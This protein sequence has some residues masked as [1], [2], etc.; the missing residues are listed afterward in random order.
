MND[1]YDCLKGPS[2]DCAV[3]KPFSYFINCD[4]NIQK[5]QGISHPTQRRG[6]RDNAATPLRYAAPLR[7]EAFP[8]GAV[9]SRDRWLAYFFPMDKLYCRLETCL[10]DIPA[11]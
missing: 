3:L 11:S 2:C 1:F 6:R 4:V 10:R 5:D 7:A 8:S 9:T